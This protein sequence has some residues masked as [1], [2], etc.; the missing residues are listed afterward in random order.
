ME[1]IWYILINDHREGPFSPEDLKK[2]SRI[3]PETLVWREGFEEWVPIGQVPELGSVF[4]DT[5]EVEEEAEETLPEEEEISLPMREKPP[6]FF[7]IFLLV[8]ICFFIYFFIKYF[9]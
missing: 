3:S 8:A 1:K 7:Y 9:R 2:D 6:F 5:E 4:K